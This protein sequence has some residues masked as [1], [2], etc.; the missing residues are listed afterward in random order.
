MTNVVEWP[1]M[2]CFLKYASFGCVW[3]TFGKPI[4]Q[5]VGQQPTSVLFHQRF[6]EAPKVKVSTLA[7]HC[8]DACGG[9][10]CQYFTG[11]RLN[12]N[13]VPIDI[14]HRFGE[15]PDRIQMI[16]PIEHKNSLVA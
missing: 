16:H 9:S 12:P 15:P 3:H 13:N 11:L 5:H 4:F 7:V 6:G 2:L 1:A 10:L 14:N 8:R